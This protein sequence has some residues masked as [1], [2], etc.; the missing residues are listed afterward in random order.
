MNTN[1]CVRVSPRYRVKRSES[2]SARHLAVFQYRGD[3]HG[4]LM[5]LFCHFPWCKRYDSLFPND[6]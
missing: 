2:A 1:V 6:V 5:F 4:A 3:N